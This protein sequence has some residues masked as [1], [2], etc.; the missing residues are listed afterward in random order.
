M[1][2]EIRELIIRAITPECPPETNANERRDTNQNQ[3]VNNRTLNKTVRSIV[4][5]AQRRKNER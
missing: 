2:V 3:A 1:P 4:D 5:N